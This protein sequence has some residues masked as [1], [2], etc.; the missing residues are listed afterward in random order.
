[1]DSSFLTGRAGAGKRL[2]DEVEVKSWHFLPWFLIKK[3]LETEKNTKEMKIV[4]RLIYKVRKEGFR[5]GVCGH[6]TSGSH[7]IYQVNGGTNAPTKKKRATDIKRGPQVMVA[8]RPYRE[9]GNG[10]QGKKGHY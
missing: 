6:V 10:H 4:H 2:S 7:I 9:G 8:A 5:R 3:S 1:V